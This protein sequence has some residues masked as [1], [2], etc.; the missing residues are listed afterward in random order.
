MSGTY[1]DLTGE[2]FNRL[3]VLYRVENHGSRACW[4]CRC[5]CGSEC[6]VETADLRSGNTKSCGCLRNEIIG[7]RSITHNKS[8]EKLYRIWIDMKKR[9][10]NRNSTSYQYYGARGITVCDEWSDYTVFREWAFKNG[11]R[12]DVPRGVCTIDRI[13]VN[14]DYSP[15]NCRWVSMKEQNSNKR[16]VCHG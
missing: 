13:D 12:D 10:Y 5:D 7:K 2:K 9:C 4:K 15:Q 16:V 1:R 14:G 11:Y 6:V 3:T 8:H